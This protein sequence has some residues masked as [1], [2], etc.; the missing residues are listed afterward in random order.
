[1]PKSS[2]AKLVRVEAIPVPAE[3]K[4]LTAKPGPKPKSTSQAAIDR[5][6]TAWQQ[7]Y[8]ADMRKSRLEPGED[9]ITSE[10]IEAIDSTY[11]RQLG[12]EAY[13][14]AMP[15]LSDHA[16]IGDFIACVTHGLLI[17]A[18]RP[19]RSGQLFYA[20]Q[21]SLNTL[22]CAPGARKQG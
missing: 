8:D 1:M 14:R 13:C 5:C 17:G 4:E 21:V 18:V 9:G 11:A 22:N 7:A 16:S 6:M 12:N 20:A 10:E 19:D 2:K 15:V 3:S